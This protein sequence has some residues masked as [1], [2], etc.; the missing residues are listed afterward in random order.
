[1]KHNFW[2]AAHYFSF[3][4]WKLKGTVKKT[5][6]YLRNSLKPNWVRIMIWPP[7]STIR[8]FFLSARKIS[9]ED[10]HPQSHSVFFSRNG[11]PPPLKIFHR[12]CYQQH[13]S[14]IT[15]K[16][17]IMGTQYP[18]IIRW[19]SPTDVARFPV[20]YP[21]PQYLSIGSLHWLA[22]LCRFP[23]P[24]KKEIKNKVQQI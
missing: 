5:T 8:F 17:K 9:A 19:Q 12:V 16:L 4:Y 11:L 15:E 18:S 23:H 14:L 1:M 21:T 3:W 20:N 7:L 22:R 2:L 10:C 24:D 13:L 6:L